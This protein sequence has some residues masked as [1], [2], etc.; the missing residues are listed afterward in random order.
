MRDVSSHYLIYAIR[1][2]FIMCMCLFVCA[3]AC[4]CACASLIFHVKG[5]HFFIK[6]TFTHYIQTIYY[7]ILFECDYYA[8]VI[9][10][11][12]LAI[13]HEDTSIIC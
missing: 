3:C 1:I 6:C 7:A 9:V 4:S 2:L 8:V 5:T 10:N 13:F 12:M 11:N